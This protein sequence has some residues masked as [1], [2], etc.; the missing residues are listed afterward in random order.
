MWGQIAAAVG[1]SLVGGYLDNQ[2]Q[3]SANDAN[4]KIARETNRFNAGQ[5]ELTREFNADEAE[6]NRLYQTQMSNTSYQRAM[7]DMKEAG[8]NPIL[9]YSQGG[10]STPSGSSASAGAAS[11]TGTR[12]EAFKRGEA[13]RQAITSAL[14]VRRLKKDVESADSQMSLNKAAEKTQAAQTLLNL[15]S[16]K[17]AH[18]NELKATTEAEINHARLP[19]IKSQSARDAQ[20]A[21][22]DSKM[23][24]YDNIQR[25]VDQGVGT[26]SKAVDS[27]NPMRLLRGSLPKGLGNRN[28]N[29]YNKKTGELYYEP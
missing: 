9:A 12:V 11:G 14:E 5:A 3:S 26:I 2:A 21:D 13:I 27:F 19:A 6:K 10:A 28:G 7:T 25:R 8:L 24:K 17:A 1:G 16:A 23:M 20:Q 18:A 4:I 15:N 22:I 29:V